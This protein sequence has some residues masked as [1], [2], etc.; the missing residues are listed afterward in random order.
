V[1]KF[2]RI[3]SADS[4]QAGIAHDAAVTSQQKFPMSFGKDE[5]VLGLERGNRLGS[6]R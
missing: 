4:K 2:E 6:C 1:A 3:F 5:F